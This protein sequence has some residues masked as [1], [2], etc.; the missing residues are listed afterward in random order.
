MFNINNNWTKFESKKMKNTCNV[1]IIMHIQC[2][3]NST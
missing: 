2:E 3:Y 1:Q